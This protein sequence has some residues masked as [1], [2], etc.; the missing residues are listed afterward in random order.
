MGGGGGG[1]GSH[2]PV[3]CSHVLDLFASS[4]S[5]QWPASTRLTYIGMPPVN[6]R[7]HFNLFNEY[8]HLIEVLSVRIVIEVCVCVCVCVV[9]V[10]ACV[11]VCVCV[12]V[13]VCVCVRVRACVRA[14]VRVCV[15]VC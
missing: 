5:K 10:R 9:C 15:C 8:P 1:G 13:C 12:S 7:P 14:C 3:T 2:E 6:L 11:R 4:P